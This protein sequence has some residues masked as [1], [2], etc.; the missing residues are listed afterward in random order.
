M[1][2]FSKLAAISLSVLCFP[3]VAHASDAAC[4]QY[5][6]QRL[7][8]RCAPI[9]TA[10][11]AEKALK[12]DIK[13][14]KDAGADTSALEAELRERKEATENARA[15]NPQ[16]DVCGDE[17]LPEARLDCDHLA[18]LIEAHL[19]GAS[20]ASSSSKA[21]AAAAKLANDVRRE[22]ISETRT[23]VNR[24]G[25]PA[26]PSAVEALRPISL[27]GA[28]FTI[29]GTR[30]GTRGVGTIT[31]NPLAL[32]SANDAVS[33]RI[34]DLSVTAPFALDGTSDQD[35]RFV[36]VRARVN[37]TAPISAAH[38]NELVKYYAAAGRLADNFEQILTNAPD[39]NKC[40]D[41]LLQK[42]SPSLETCGAVLNVSP[43]DVETLRAQAKRAIASARREAD[44]YYLGLDLR[45]DRG[46]PTG[47]LL[48]GDRGTR[49]FGAV[50]GG[51]RVASSE[52]WE[53]ELRMH[54]GG[55]YFR[56]LDRLESGERPEPIFSFDWGT[57]LVVNGYT[58]GTTDKQHIGFGV[59][60]QGRHSNRSASS[61]VA[62]TNFL[63]LSL[64]AI[65]PAAAGADIGVAATV[66]LS[67]AKVPQ[68]MIISFSTD[69]G[70]LDGTS[71]ATSN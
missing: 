70:L 7:A 71:T 40:A 54:A 16:A 12:K 30:V 38:L 19:G 22:Q 23:S 35:V 15:A 43:S 9:W 26:Q 51:L 67:D 24:S 44:R 63:N 4:K 69:L 20:A 46:D 49:L 45:F 28:A 60:L 1:H 27:A 56:G 47:T 3:A 11:A 32:G 68:G 2:S 58:H 59:G 39:V 34:F 25:S 66:P 52:I 55:D 57:A 5:F 37:A 42:Q 13:E 64:M 50:G 29:A 18:T 21:G 62:P 53:L 6:Q 14:K 10:V 61:D 36:G 41:A 65:V 17:G 8:P 33:G 48:P 31:V